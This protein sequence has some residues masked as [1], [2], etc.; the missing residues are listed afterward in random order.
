MILANTATRGDP[1]GKGDKGDRGDV[2]P[3]AEPAPLWVPG[4]YRAGTRRSHAMGR[5]YEAA[6]DTAAEPGESA[7]WRRLGSTGFAVI[8]GRE[9]T[10]PGDF[11]LRDG[12]TF[13]FDG[14]KSWLVFPT[15]FTR[16]DCEALLKPTRSSVRDLTSSAHAQAQRIDGVADVARGADARSHEVAAWV[17]E[18]GPAL[19][20][21]L[22]ANRPKA[23]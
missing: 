10:E 3:V 1:G 9:P 15:P 23:A 8:G 17:N 13:L 11:H 22:L 7:D 2:G 20:R 5:V 4:V 16:S 18:Y 6:T 19:V 14:A 21:L 12:A